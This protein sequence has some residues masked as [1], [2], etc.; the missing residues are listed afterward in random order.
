MTENGMRN[1]GE[2]GRKKQVRFMEFMEVAEERLLIDDR[3]EGG[4]KCIEQK[5]RE[6]GRGKK[7]VK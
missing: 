7:L 2:Q 3:K 5:M 1:R 4:Y 6:D